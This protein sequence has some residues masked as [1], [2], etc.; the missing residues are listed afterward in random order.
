MYIFK[1]IVCIC[2]LEISTYIGITLGKQLK[3]RTKEYVTL[4]SICTYIESRIKYSQDNLIDI[5]DDVHEQNKNNNFGFLFEDITNQMKKNIYSL[6][7][8]IS[9]GISNN[10]Y[11][12]CCDFNVL[13]ELSNS[14]GKSNVENQVKAIEL[15]KTRIKESLDESKEIENKNSKLY[16]NLGVICGIMLVIVLI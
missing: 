5:F 4:Q 8:C 13:Q 3:N 10:Q 7:E 1:L 12:F 15:A 6:S 11:R 2:I 14:L 9:R 16:R